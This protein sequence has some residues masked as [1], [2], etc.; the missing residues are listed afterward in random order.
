MIY[1]SGINRYLST[2]F[3]LI[4]LQWSTPQYGPIRSKWASRSDRVTWVVFITKKDGGHSCS[5]LLLLGTRPMLCLT[6]FLHWQRVNSQLS[7]LASLISKW[8][9]TA[10]AVAL[11][12]VLCWDKCFFRFLW[13][14]ILETSLLASSCYL[15]TSRF[16]P[17]CYWLV[18]LNLLQ[19]DLQ[20]GFFTSLIF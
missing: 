11:D 3:N 1:T 8:Q 14:L 20:M 2:R 9:P 5:L 4:R 10:P 12:T 7:W 13:L 16:S 19:C 17:V 15:L 18:S 6:M